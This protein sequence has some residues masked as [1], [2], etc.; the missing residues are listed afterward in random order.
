VR[1]KIP[2]RPQ[3][4]T[5]RPI[6]AGPQTAIV[7]G[8]PGEE[9]F[10]DELGRVKVQFHWD[11][12]GG[13]NDQSSCWVR[14]AQAGASS[15]FGSIQIPRVED[16]VVVVFLDGNP[17]RPLIIGS[18]YNSS[19]TPPWALPANKTQSGLL[20]RSIKGDG[21]TANFLR[22]DDK[23]GAER[24]SLHAERNL[25]TEVEADEKRK[26][27][28]NR[29]IT[30]GGRHEETIRLE[31]SIAVEEGSY[32]VTVDHG[33]VR[34]KAATSITLEVGSCMLRMEANGKVIL[35]GV[36]LDLAGSSIINLNKK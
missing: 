8:P 32:L 17:D 5:P 25:D 11:R 22:F 20:T 21:R 16:E 24:V 3:L 28:G 4:T 15:G 13:F 27:G 2:F 36:E 7:V 29:S 35:S 12:H 30:V 10:T 33:A 14:V 1:K 18:L 19:N 31:S 9:I 34:I 23:N 6:I 26:V